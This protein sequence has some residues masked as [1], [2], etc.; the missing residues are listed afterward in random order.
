MSKI[1]YEEKTF[2]GV[3]PTTP[4]IPRTSPSNATADAADGSCVCLPEAVRCLWGDTLFPSKTSAKKSIRKGMFSVLRRDDNDEEATATAASCPYVRGRCDTR[5]AVGDRLRRV[6]VYQ[7]KHVSRA[8]WDN[9]TGSSTA[10]VLRRAIGGKLRIAYRDAALAVVIKPQGMP[11]PKL[12]R[13]QQQQPQQPP[14]T[15]KMTT[16][17]KVRE[18]PGTTNPERNDADTDTPIVSLYELLLHCMP[19]PQPF[20]TAAGAVSAT[21]TTTIPNEDEATNYDTIMRRPVPVHRLDL[22]TYG[23]VIVART[24]QTERYLKYHCFQERSPLL[25][26]R[27][28]AIVYGHLSSTATPSGVIKVPLK[29][30]ECV[31]EY[32]VVKR[33]TIPTTGTIHNNDTNNTSTTSDDAKGT[34]SDSSSKKIEDISSASAIP[35]GKEIART[36]FTLVD[37]Y[38]QTGRNHQLRRHMLALGHPIVGDPRYYN[39]NLQQYKYTGNKDTTVVVPL[40]LAAVELTFPHPKFVPATLSSSSSSS[41]SSSLPQQAPQQQSSTTTT[42]TNSRS[43]SSS[44]HN[45][46]DTTNNYVFAPD[47]NTYVDRAKGTVN[48]QI[49][50]PRPMQELLALSLS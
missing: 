12:K 33:F 10:D 40:M 29:G 43:S 23:L 3:V 27:Y 14:K 6:V 31:T 36:P 26:K 47:A 2:Q 11:V 20:I 49:D 16:T 50:M 24:I 19:Q 25:K 39:H 21:A 38:P 22:L 42:T 46:D 28:R 32:R 45:K 18:D 15:T 44:S 17:K 9:T 5:I 35:M 48:V 13:Q 4:T 8:T 37:L 30:K 41:S 1:T 7:R 34:A